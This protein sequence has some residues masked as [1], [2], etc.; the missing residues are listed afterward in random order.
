MLE[1]SLLDTGGLSVNAAGGRGGGGGGGG[2]GIESSI[3]DANILGLQVVTTLQTTESG[4]QRYLELC[5]RQLH[6]KEL[7]LD[8]FIGPNSFGK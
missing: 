5:D 6:L 1:W 3:E 4:R 2:G 7:V 8:H